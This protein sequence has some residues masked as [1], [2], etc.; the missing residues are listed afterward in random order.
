M[1]TKAILADTHDPKSG[2]V[3]WSLSALLFVPRP[4]T[5]ITSEPKSDK[6]SYHAFHI[7]LHMYIQSTCSTYITRRVTL[8][9]RA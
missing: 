2:V 3:T 6:P 4:K 5:L 1:I 9:A 8:G 7:T